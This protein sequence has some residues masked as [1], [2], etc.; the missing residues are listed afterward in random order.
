MEARRSVEY[1][2][3]TW[4]GPAKRPASAVELTDTACWHGVAC[5]TRRAISGRT[6]GIRK[7]Y[8][9]ALEHATPNRGYRLTIEFPDAGIHRRVHGSG[10]P[11]L[12]RAEDRSGIGVSQGFLEAACNTSA[13]GPSL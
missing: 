2:S 6:C 8:H 5:R 1:S 9:D 10:Y 4:M 11:V 3:A 12:Q 13:F 7:L